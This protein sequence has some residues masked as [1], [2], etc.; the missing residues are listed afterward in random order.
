M[1]KLIISI[2]ARLR[3][4][5]FERLYWRAAEILTDAGGAK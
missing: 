4:Y 2:L 3:P 5:G 1:S